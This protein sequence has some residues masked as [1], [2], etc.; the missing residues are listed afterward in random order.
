MTLNSSKLSPNGSAIPKGFKLSLWNCWNRDSAS[1]LMGQHVP[2]RA[3][4]LILVTGPIRANTCRTPYPR[5]ASGR[6]ACPCSGT[7]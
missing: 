5:P 2:T 7:Q 6:W 4:P 3:G 1:E